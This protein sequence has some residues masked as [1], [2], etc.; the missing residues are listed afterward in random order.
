MG[1]NQFIERQRALGLYRECMRLSK[2]PFIFFLVY[3]PLNGDLD[4]HAD[5]V[6]YYQSYPRGLIEMIYANTSAASLREVVG[7][8]KTW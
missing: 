1:Y 6:L 7:A 2:C 4:E 8:K 5:P 3:I